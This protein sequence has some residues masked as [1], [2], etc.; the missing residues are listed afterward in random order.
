MRLSRYMLITTSIVYL[1]GIAACNSTHQVR[2]RVVDSAKDEPIAH[3]EVRAELR[4][5]TM[6]VSNGLP[7]DFPSVQTAIT[8]NNGEVVV[9]LVSGKGFAIIASRDGY[10][11]N[12]LLLSPWKPGKGDEILEVRLPPIE[13]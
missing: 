10:H 1:S 9:D 2:V 4:T 5:L 7:K 6:F 13:P 3:A 12:D 8:D 11:E